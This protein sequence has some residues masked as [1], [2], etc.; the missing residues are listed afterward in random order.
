VSGELILV[1]D[2]NPLNLKLMRFL[3]LKHG[4]R[5]AT[6]MDAPAALAAIALEL[7]RLVVMDLQLPGMDGLTLTQQL[8]ATPGWEHIPILAVTASAMRGDEQRALAAGCSGYI[9]K[10]IDTRALPA[11]LASYLRPERGESR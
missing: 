10:P 6:A 8:R 3:L 4:H 5:V 11:Q 7:P 2:D 1:V 9:T